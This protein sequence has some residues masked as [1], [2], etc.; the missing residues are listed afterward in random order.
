MGNSREYISV[1]DFCHRF[2]ITPDTFKNWLKTK[3]I[4]SLNVKGKK[5]TCC[6]VERLE[7]EIKK[8]ELLIKKDLRFLSLEKEINKEVSSY[9]S[10]FSQVI[11][12]DEEM[13]ALL[14]IIESF[15]REVGINLLYIKP[16]GFKT[17]ETQSKY[18]IDLN[19]QGEMNQVIDFI[20]RIESSKK[21]LIVERL[22]IV[23]ESEESSIA[24][25]RITVSEI[26][27]P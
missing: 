7:E 17:D 8:K 11:S 12:A 3:V 22:S 5:I 10:Y 19:C 27:I 9:Q 4:N 13:N 26:G 1:Q 20:Y 2:K 16:A 23:P 14:K 15:A 6:E 24:N 21:L 25:C 18:S